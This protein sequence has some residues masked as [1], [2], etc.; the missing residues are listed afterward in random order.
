MNKANI[1][2]V[3]DEV[4]NLSAFKAAFRR[5]FNVFVAESAEKGFDVLES[6]DIHVLLTDQRM[7]EITGIDFL[8]SVI[9]KHPKPIRMLITGYT[10]VEVIKEAINEG[11]VYKYIDKPWNN[12]QL[13]N[14][15][16][17]ALEVYL[18]R[19]ENQQLT[20]DLKRVNSQLE[21]MLRQRLSS[22]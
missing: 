11:H 13:K 22:E 8:K 5:D 1:L 2:Y 21:F 6:Q 19:E 7:P 17:K 14:S 9:E 12:D 15:I 4:E 20:K 16:D 18:L 3:D 10:D